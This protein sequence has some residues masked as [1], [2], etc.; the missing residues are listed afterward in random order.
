MCLIYECHQ[1]QGLTGSKSHFV[2]LLYVVLMSQEI[3]AYSLWVCLRVCFSHSEARTPGYCSSRRS[4]WWWTMGRSINSELYSAVAHQ[5]VWHEAAV[6]LCL[7][8]FSGTWYV[9]WRVGA[10]LFVSAI[11]VAHKFRIY[12]NVATT[13]QFFKNRVQGSFSNNGLGSFWNSYEFITYVHVHV[14]VTCYRCV[15]HMHCHGFA[16]I[17]HLAVLLRLKPC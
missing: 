3:A 4:Q 10:C 16:S 7:P 14:I 8:C 13:K 2:S 5:C 6:C 9:S 17:Y 11:M 12:G 1:Y 15:C